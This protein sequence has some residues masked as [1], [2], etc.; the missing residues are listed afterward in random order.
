MK[1]CTKFLG[2]IIDKFLDFNDHIQHIKGKIS[3]SIGILLK[4][5]RVFDKKTLLTL[6]N[7]FL[8]PH[9]NYCISVWGNTYSSYLEPLVKLQK[10]A[11][12]IIMG[13]KRNSPTDPIFWKLKI[14]KFKQIYLYSVQQ[15]VFKFHHRMLPIIF[16][17]FFSVNDSFHTHN[18]LRVLF[19]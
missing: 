16:N 17:D 12:R 19:K 7:S 6:Y 18:T 2:V 11:V 1:N 8:Y 13:V 3:R 15:F 10:R 4:C 9:L 14:L 5:R